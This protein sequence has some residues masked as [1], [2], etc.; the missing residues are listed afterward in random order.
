[1]ELNWEPLELR[2]GKNRCA[3]FMF[4][5]RANGVNLYKDGIA[6]MYLNL[7]DL[8]HLGFPFRSYSRYSQVV[9]VPLSA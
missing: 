8:E 7:D 3:R 5:G 6:R 1:M 9:L 4:M 2:P